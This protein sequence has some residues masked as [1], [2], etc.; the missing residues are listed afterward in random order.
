MQDFLPSYQLHRYLNRHLDDIINDHKLQSPPDYIE[1]EETSQAVSPQVSFTS[2]H[3]ER[4]GMSSLASDAQ[5]SIWNTI[6]KHQYMTQD[7]VFIDIQL[8][9]HSNVHYSPYTSGDIVKGAVRVHNITPNP[10]PFENIFV[11]FEGYFWAIKTNFKMII[12]NFLDMV[13]FEASCLCEDPDS[14]LPL[15]RILRPNSSYV[16]RFKFQIPEYSKKG[17]PLPPSVG[18]LHLRHKIHSQI[19]DTKFLRDSFAHRDYSN[20][21]FS[22][23]Y[24]VNARLLELDESKKRLVIR[25]HSRHMIMFTPTYHEFKFRYLD[26]AD[27]LRLLVNSLEDLMSNHLAKRENNP[28]PKRVRPN[29]H[30]FRVSEDREV[31]RLQLKNDPSVVIEKYLDYTTSSQFLNSNANLTVTFKEDIK[32]KCIELI[33]INYYTQSTLPV[34]LIADWFVNHVQFETTIR[35][36]FKELEQVLADCDDEE[37]LNMI[38]SFSNLRF[39]TTKMPKVITFKKS[40]PFAYTISLAKTKRDVVVPS[41][42]FPYCGRLYFMRF[43]VKLP[44]GVLHNGESTL[45]FDIPIS[46]NS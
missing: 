9:D 24:C 14:G 23:S 22:I 30:K 28:D 46:L 3:L 29:R 16:V 2:Q 45:V 32:V 41:F 35:P 20:E 13:D 33:A 44:V 31:F 1:V 10:I 38:R 21:N 17:F 37:A 4:D 5:N 11:S 39:S 26:P 12:N 15:D 27:E 25:R 40:A 43:Q 19:Q 34:S 7:A 8:D 42:E 36:K 6:D 18:D